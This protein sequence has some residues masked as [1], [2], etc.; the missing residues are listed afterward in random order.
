MDGPVPKVEIMFFAQIRQLLG[1]TKGRQFEIR[2]AFQILKA[3]M[4]QRVACYQKGRL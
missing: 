3:Q 2:N 4:R 1:L